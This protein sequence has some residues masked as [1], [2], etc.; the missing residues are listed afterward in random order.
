[1]T[2]TVPTITEIKFRG[3]SPQLTDLLRRNTQLQQRAKTAVIGRTVARF[4]MSS[5]EFVLLVNHL[6]E[7]EI[8]GSGASSKEV[9]RLRGLR[10]SFTAA[11]AGD[12]DTGV[13]LVTEIVDPERQ[14]I[15]GLL[16]QLWHTVD[17]EGDIDLARKVAEKLTTLAFGDAFQIAGV[18]QIRDWLDEHL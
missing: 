10:A 7:H 12:E 16:A 4:K 13:T 14:E 3:L 5:D 1:M 11:L 15:L 8:T 6:I 2:L 17:M 18:E 9:K